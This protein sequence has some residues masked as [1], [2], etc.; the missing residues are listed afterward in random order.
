MKLK[1]WEV[2]PLPQHRKHRQQR[3]APGAEEAPWPWKGR[4]AVELLLGLLGIQSFCD[5][6][7]LE[8]HPRRCSCMQNNHVDAT[9]KILCIYIYIIIYIYNV[10]LGLINPTG[11]N[12]LHCPKHFGNLKTSGPPGLKNCL[13]WT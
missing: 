7:L 1:P 11:L 3:S 10:E 4:R 13:A 9:H 8:Q 6:S 2:L 5:M 12:N